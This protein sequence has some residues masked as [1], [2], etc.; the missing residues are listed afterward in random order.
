L[1]I[2]QRWLMFEKQNANK[3]QWS[4]ERKTTP[5]D[6]SVAYFW[7]N[8]NEVQLYEEYNHKIT[9]KRLQSLIIKGQT[10]NR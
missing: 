4:W 9:Q 5:H 7:K 1:L 2:N 3:T 8:F 10:C 6:A